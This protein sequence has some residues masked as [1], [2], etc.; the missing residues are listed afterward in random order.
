MSTR[1]AQYGGA[2][3][4]EGSV[5]HL[6]NVTIAD[7]NATASSPHAAGGGVA[8]NTS[9]AI[10][11]KTRLEQCRA[12]MHGGGLWAQTTHLTAVQSTFQSNSAEMQGGGLFMS[13]SFLSTT[14]CTFQSNSA[15]EGAALVYRSLRSANDNTSTMS[16]A[17]FANNTGHSIIDIQQ[18]VEWTCERGQYMPYTDRVQE[19]FANFYGCARKCAA[20]TIWTGPHHR[21]GHC[22]G[23]C[24]LGSYC[25][26]GQPP[27]P[28]PH[29]TYNPVTTAT[30]RESCIPCRPGTYNNQQGG[31]S[32][33]AC[34]ACPPGTLSEAVGAAS[35]VACPY[36]GYCAAEGAATVRQTYTPC[37]AG[38]YN[39]STGSA[40]N[41]S[42][43]ACPPGK[44]NPI[45]GSSS[46]D[47]CLECLPG[48]A[49][50]TN[51]TATCALCEPG[52]RQP[53]RGQL[54]CLD[55]IAGS[56]CVQGSVLPAPCAAGT[57]S[58]S[59]SLTSDAECTLTAPGSF[60]P[61]GSTAPTPCA[62]GSFAQEEGSERCLLCPSGKHQ[63]AARQTA[64]IQCR[65]GTRCS[66]GVS[67]ELP[68]EAGT[69]QPSAAQSRCIACT[70]GHSCPAGSDNQIECEAGTYGDSADWTC[71]LCEEGSF[72]R[73]A[74]QT[75]CELCPL[76][77]AC[78]LGSATPQP[79]TAGRF[80]ATPGQ[81][82][83]DCTGACVKGHYCPEGSTSNTSGVCRER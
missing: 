80:G 47:V 71:K 64:C 5:V 35:C 68:C 25:E 82:S 18:K 29:G 4:A 41:A 3:F 36:G 74:R 13:T 50:P 46:G 27:K 78:S 69:H 16:K 53:A 24:P 70:P 66:Q 42:C 26:E 45:P 21:S 56:F 20:G 60:S 28:C 76:G 8:L 23:D 61:T 44:A 17:T 54:G 12:K 63:P 11:E 52:K 83:R 19:R 77:F 34:T 67:K 2:I 57:H 73:N 33:S 10:L 58:N 72:Q 65:A 40:S 14:E 43:L 31:N 79:C 15:P 7:A 48:S 55:C 38:S 81:T 6:T 30:A 22:G 75:S 32:S 51:G 62:P 1:A 9:E 39:P 37:Q 49:A 59:T